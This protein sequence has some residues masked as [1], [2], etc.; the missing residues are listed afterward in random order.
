M[1]DSS[2]NAPV[3]KKMSTSMVIMSACVI[4]VA[5]GLFGL[6][7]WHASKCTSSRSPD[8]IEEYVEALNR[9]LLQAESKVRKCSFCEAEF[10]YISGH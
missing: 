8:E 5:I 9:R 7:Y 1:R 4:G 3:A 10:D 6:N 2:S